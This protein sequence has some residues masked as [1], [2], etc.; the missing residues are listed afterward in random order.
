MKNIPSIKLNY[1]WMTR[2]TKLLAYRHLKYG[3]HNELQNLQ[4]QTEKTQ[5]NTSLTVRETSTYLK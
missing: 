3:V 4:N 1:I 2:E 5:T